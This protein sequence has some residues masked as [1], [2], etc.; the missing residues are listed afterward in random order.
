MTPIETP[1]QKE[2]P[3]PAAEPPHVPVIPP[4][5]FFFA[6]ALIAAIF[7]VL[8]AWLMLEGTAI[9]AFDRDC[10]IYWQL[11][12][13]AHHAPWRLMVFL[14]DLGGI[15]SMTL[16]AIMGAIW[17]TAIKHRTLAYAWLVIVIGGAA[18]NQGF[19]SAHDRPRPSNPDIAVLEKNA[20]FPS[21]HSTSSAIGFGM[22]GYALVLP[23]R[24]RPR[25][26]VAV[27][28]M[29][30]IVLAI[31]FSRMYLRAHW[32]SDVIGGWAVGTA[33]LFFCLGWYE[34][35]RRRRQAQG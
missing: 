13:E 20:S 31:G 1:T 32:F 14:T 26:V 5:R 6:V 29:I 11:W 17:Q 8:W 12:S 30:A 33:W 2:T 24:H 23:Q 18:L 4:P 15:A 27:N 21:G 3:P 9:K 22:L 25:R 10:A 16:L 7:Y 19:K 28:L 35:Y 34:R